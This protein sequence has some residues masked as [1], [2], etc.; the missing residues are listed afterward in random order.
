MLQAA[1]PLLASQRVGG[2]EWSFDTLDQQ[3]A[4][5]DWFG[6]LLQHYAQAGRLVGHGVFFSLFSG[7]WHSEQQAWL[8]LLALLSQQYQFD[9]ITEHFGFMSGANFHQGAPLSPPFNSATLT[10]GHDRLLR[11]QDACRCPV[12]LENLAIAYRE[13]EVKRQGDFLAQLLVPVNGFIILDLH[14]LYCQ[15]HNF[16]LDLTEMCAYYPLHLV[17][18]IH[19]SGGSWDEIAQ[20]PEGRIR[21]DTHDHGVPNQVFDMLLQVIPLCPQ[22]KY[23]VLEQL[24]TALHTSEQQAQFQADFF[25]MDQLVQRAAMLNHASW[26][27]HPFTP[28]SHHKISVPPLENIELFEQ[29]HQLTR[30]LEQADCVETAS[31]LLSQSSLAQ[32]DWK[33]EQWPPYMLETA[34]KV[35][36]KWQQGWLSAVH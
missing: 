21:R 2:I 35:A 12:G 13:E 34:L 36:Q 4:I 28:P 6:D 1:L 24:G 26:D 5:P 20:A 32:S 25:R 8:N 27:E 22:L 19:I 14:N 16:Q 30:I 23:V 10:L 33:V 9:H 15:L 31:L 17:R 11:I 29:Q 18:E 7:R 3:Q